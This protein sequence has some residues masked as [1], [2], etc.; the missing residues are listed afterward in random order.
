ML[1]LSY[2]AKDLTY[3]IF[4]CKKRMIVNKTNAIFFVLAVTFLVGAVGMAI[5]AEEK[6]KVSKSQSVAQIKLFETSSKFKMDCAEVA[7]YSE[8]SGKVY[9]C[10]NIEVVCYTVGY[11]LESGG[12]N[13]KFK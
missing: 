3:V 7:P 4:Y 2:N 9:R 8:N 5:K 13:C 1:V 10:E 11:G 12:V 6:N